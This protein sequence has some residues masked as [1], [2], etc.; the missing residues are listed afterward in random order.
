MGRKEHFQDVVRQSKRGA[1]Q[2]RLMRETRIC[3]KKGREKE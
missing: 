1:K 2:R 3:E